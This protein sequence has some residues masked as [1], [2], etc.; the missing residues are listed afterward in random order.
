MLEVG[1][2]FCFKGHVLGILLSC[3]KSLY[4]SNFS[5]NS[6]SF[7]FLNLFEIETYFRPI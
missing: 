5:F 2:V 4:L 6:F 1:D 7:N 3:G